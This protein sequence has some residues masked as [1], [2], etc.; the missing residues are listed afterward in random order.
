MGYD[1]RET[2]TLLLAALLNNKENQAEPEKALV[3]EAIEYT[4]MLFSEMDRKA[5]GKSKRSET[6]A[7]VEID[8]VNGVNAKAL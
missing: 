3:A 4:E 6:W 8:F 1:K 7:S 2:A 5:T